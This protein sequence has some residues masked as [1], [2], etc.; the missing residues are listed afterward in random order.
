LDPGVKKEVWAML[1]DKVTL[2][3]PIERVQQDAEPIATIYRSLGTA[4]A[5]QVVTR[6]LGELAMTMAGLS[7]QVRNQDLQNVSRQLRRLQRMAENLG[8]VSLALV[9]SDVRICLDQGDSTAF[10]SVWA[11][12]IRIAER[13]LSPDKDLLDQSLI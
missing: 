5:E 13:S 12:L 10:A 1:P 3:R 4:S 7:N 9:S 6:A 8:M 2:L 11:R